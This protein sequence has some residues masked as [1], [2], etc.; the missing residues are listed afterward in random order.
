M[1]YEDE[2]QE[3]HEE[4]SFR[5]KEMENIKKLMEQDGFIVL[6]NVLSQ[7]MVNSYKNLIGNYFNLDGLGNGK[8]MFKPDSFNTP[9]LFD[10]IKISNYLIVQSEK[11]NIN[12]R[13]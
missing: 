13:M 8:T 6:K 9:E 7:E 10:L 2:M 12:W 4:M 3:Y 5:R 11:N 1:S